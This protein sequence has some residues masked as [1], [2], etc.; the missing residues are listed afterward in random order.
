MK[1]RQ[2]ISFYP[3]DAEYQD[4]ERIKQALERRTNSDAIRAMIRLCKKILAQSG[5]IA[6]E[7][8]PGK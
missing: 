4:F 7:M 6:P 8:Q 3:D 5:A 1:K 2:H